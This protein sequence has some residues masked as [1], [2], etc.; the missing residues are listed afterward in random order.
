MVLDINLFIIST[1]LIWVFP[2]LFLNL[3]IPQM[4]FTFFSLSPFCSSRTTMPSTRQ[5]KKTARKEQT[6]SSGIVVHTSEPLYGKK[7]PKADESEQVCFFFFFLN[8]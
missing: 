4:F 6:G 3:Q 7:Q 2:S 1:E 8:L 5:F